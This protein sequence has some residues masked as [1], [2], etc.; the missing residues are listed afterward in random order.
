MPTEPILVLNPRSDPE[1]VRFAEVT[2][3]NGAKTPEAYQA[4]LRE[5]YPQAVVQPRELA[6]EPSTIWYCYRDGRLTNGRRSGA[7][8][9]DVGS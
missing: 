8:V 3:A 6:S 7:E 9:G 4:R 5:R 2:L 1:F